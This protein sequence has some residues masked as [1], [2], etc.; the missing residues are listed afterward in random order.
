[1]EDWVVTE[2]LEDHDGVDE[3]WVVIFN[4]PKNYAADG[5][6]SYSFPKKTF[7]YRAAEFGYDIDDPD[8]REALFQ[9]VLHEGYLAATGQLTARGQFNPLN[10]EK[11]QAK[12]LVQERFQ[13]VQAKVRMSQA[14]KPAL[15]VAGLAAADVPADVLDV[16]RGDMRLDRDLIVEHSEKVSG[17]RESR[18]QQVRGGKAS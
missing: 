16:I 15:K 13:A 1:M 14:A 10:S 18:M 6:F 5:V 8:D 3:R 9:H 12:T 7:A 2:I 4:V 11:H 17:W